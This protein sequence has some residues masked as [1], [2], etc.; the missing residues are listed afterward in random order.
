MQHPRHLVCLTSRQ[1]SVRGAV[2]VITMARPSW[3]FDGAISV[4]IG[5][6]APL[7]S[8]LSLGS[9]LWHSQAFCT[10]LQSPDRQLL[11]L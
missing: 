4:G 7:S 3:H 1:H 5:G 10:N 2:V 11:L 6:E 9:L 8:L